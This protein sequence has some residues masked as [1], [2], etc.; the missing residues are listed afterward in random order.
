MDAIRQ[1]HRTLITGLTKLYDTFIALHYVSASDVLRPPHTS[2]AIDVTRLQ[3]L[4]FESEVIDLVQLLPALRNEV[5]WG[6]QAQG[7]QIVPRSKAVN[8]FVQPWRDVGDD[9]MD[10]LRRG[11][12]AVFDEAKVLHPWMLRLTDGGDY[13]VHLIYDTKERELGFQFSP[14]YFIYFLLCVSISTN[15]GTAETKKGGEIS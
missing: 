10:Q 13:G 9:L 1:K 3:G 4:G 12:F 11:D 7:T 15:F 6:Y 5:T 14:F 8:Y 2:P